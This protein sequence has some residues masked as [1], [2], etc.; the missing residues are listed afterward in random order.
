[1]A[2]LSCTPAVKPP[3]KIILY[4]VMF[5]LLT[6]LVMDTSFQS[7]PPPEKSTDWT[8]PFLRISVQ[9]GKDFVVFFTQVKYEARPSGHQYLEIISNLRFLRRKK[10]PSFSHP[11][12][13]FLKLN[14]IC[15]FY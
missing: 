15:A 6:S 14:Y 1:M 7:T 3:L 8:A 4:V 9:E 12:T 10:G 2:L 5:L 11:I 13:Y